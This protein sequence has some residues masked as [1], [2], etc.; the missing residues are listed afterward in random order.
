MSNYDETALWRQIQLDKMQLDPMTGHSD[1]LRHAIYS[2]AMHGS[3]CDM[4]NLTP[5]PTVIYWQGPDLEETYQRNVSDAETR[6]KLEQW[7][8]IG[9]KIDYEINSWGFRSRACTDFDN[10]TDPTLVTLGC[11][12]TFGTGLPGNSIWP[13]LAADKLE[14]RLA[15]LATPGH[16]L[17]L[18]ARWLLSE[19]Y[20]LQNPRAVVVY[21]PPPNRITWIAQH[22]RSLIADTFSMT[23]YEQYELLINSVAV[24]GFSSY[25]YDISA[26]KLWAL[27]RNIP[28]LIFEGFPCTGDADGLARDMQHHGETW[29]AVAANTVLEKLVDNK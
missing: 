18:G 1:I 9:K 21:I 7:G 4:M 15:N 11:S 28:V 22:G 19:G 3:G 26:I 10:I 25:H 24:N 14:W 16:G 5:Q 8:W 17:T 2:N 20:R 29:H 23:K 27:S 6:H 13:Q 12:F